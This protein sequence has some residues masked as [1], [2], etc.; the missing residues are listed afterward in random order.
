MPHVESDGVESDGV[1]AQPCAPGY[2]CPNISAQVPCP[3]G[4]FCKAFSTAPKRCPWLA[5]CLAESGSADL[6]LGGFLA[7]F[8]ILGLLWLAY[9]ALSAYIRCTQ[10]LVLSSALWPGWLPGAAGIG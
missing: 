4:H 10:W 3:E 8:L 9:V 5:T 7:M 1:D 6:S 2:Y